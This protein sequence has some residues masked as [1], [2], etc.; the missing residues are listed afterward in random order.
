MFLGRLTAGRAGA[1]WVSS[2]NNDQPGEPS[3]LPKSLGR[4]R[5]R[6]GVLLRASASL[7]GF[8]L[9]LAG[10]STIVL[11]SQTP[12]A[13]GA[14]ISRIA[15]G[16]TG[17]DDFTDL[18]DRATFIDLDGGYD[19]AEMANCDDDPRGGGGG[20]ELHGA[21]GFDDV[22]GQA[23]GDRPSN[24]HAGNCGKLFGGSESDNVFGGAGPDDIDDSQAGNDTDPVFGDDGNDVINVADGDPD[25]EANGGAGTDTCFT[26]SGDFRSSCEGG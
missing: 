22:R 20:D 23:D 7:F 19:V 2:M 5:L 4:P 3:E 18:T 1:I 17:D 12:A 14:C 8:L 9:G 25:D 11:L 6:R 10:G 26:D 24:C 16:T 15:N 13:A 21:A